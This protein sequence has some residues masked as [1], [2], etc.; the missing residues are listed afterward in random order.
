[1][2]YRYYAMAFVYSWTIPG[3]GMAP[4]IAWAFVAKHSISWRGG[5]WLLVAV[6]VVAL[7]CWVLFYFPPTFHQKHKRDNDSVVHWIKNF[8]YVGTFLFASG[9][10]VFLLGLSWGGSVYP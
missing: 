9:F 10:V 8:D 6:N 3:S 7:L 4:A 2:R 5:Y 1:M